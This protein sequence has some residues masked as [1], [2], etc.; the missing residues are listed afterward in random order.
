M[1]EENAKYSNYGNI[2][3]IEI[4]QETSLIWIENHTKLF[5]PFAFWYLFI[6]I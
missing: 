6:G 2:E 1:E 3:N 4:Q 5:L